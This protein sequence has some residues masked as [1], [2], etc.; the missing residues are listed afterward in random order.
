[1]V[2]LS[3]TGSA[4]PAR[5]SN[6]PMSR[7]SANG[8][9]RGLAPPDVSISALSHACRSSVRVSPPNMAARSKP[10]GR[11]VRLI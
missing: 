9:T 5:C 10:S 11:S 4:K 1:M 3:T 6:I 7:R 2:S 8:E